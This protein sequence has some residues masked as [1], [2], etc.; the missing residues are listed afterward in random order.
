MLIEVGA[1]DESA[2]VANDGELELQ[3]HERHLENHANVNTPKRKLVSASEQWRAVFRYPH[4][5]S[6]IVS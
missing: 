5:Q 2:A 1:H 3:G 4:T 6:F